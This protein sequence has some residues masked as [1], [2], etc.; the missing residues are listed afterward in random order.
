L[1]GTAG[2]QWRNGIYT[3]HHHR[4]RAHEAP[5]I[6][7]GNGRVL[8]GGPNGRPLEVSAG[9]CVLLPAGTGHCRLSVSPD[10]L[11]FGAYPPATL[12]MQLEMIR[13]GAG[14]GAIDVRKG[15]WREN[16]GRVRSWLGGARATKSDLQVRSETLGFP[17]K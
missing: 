16:A 9:D 13:E 15:C 11:V 2:R 7:S 12:N 4:A 5:G 6:A 10:F 17:G 1:T 3:F 14:G 8:L